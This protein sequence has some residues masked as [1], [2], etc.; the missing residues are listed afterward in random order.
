[1]TNSEA[2]QIYY[3]DAARATFVLTTKGINP[4]LS[5]ENPVSGAW[6]MIESATSADYSQGRTSESLSS[7]ARAQ[8]LKNAKQILE[9]NGIYWNDGST[10]TVGAAKW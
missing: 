2:F 6:G 4:T 9:D 10:P 7:G 1:M 5:D 8:L 3:P